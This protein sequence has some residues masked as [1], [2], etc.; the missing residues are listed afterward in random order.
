[1]SLTKEAL[2]HLEQS[3]KTGDMLL[4]GE[5]AIIGEQFNLA[6]LEKYGEHRRRFRGS[7]K[8]EGL[9]D[10]TT[11][12]ADR[13][14][15]GTPVFIDR[16]SMS[17]SC[18]LDIGTQAKPGHCEHRAT[19]SLPKTPEFEAFH[20][21]N[22]DT[23]DQ[24]SVIELLEDWGHLMTFANSAGEDLPYAKVL[25][26]FRKVSIDDL[27]SVD[28]ERQEHSSQASVM[29]KVSV[30]HADRLPATVTWNLP[31]YEGLQERELTMRLSTLT[32]KADK[33]RF[34]LR[35]IA[36]DA[37]EKEIAKEFA[38]HIQTDLTGCECLL[39]SFSA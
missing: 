3:H 1:M 32:A 19:L 10:F 24:D 12:V 20:R 33:P 21:V 9:E 22:G 4:D 35:A 13:A 37:A 16:D 14:Q 28:S 18:I 6:D 30:K 7:F 8:T 23:Y 5:V 26:A 25:T 15:S 39:G 29:S 2:Q 31:T 17:A 34:R 38:Q 36:L 11:Y 27:T